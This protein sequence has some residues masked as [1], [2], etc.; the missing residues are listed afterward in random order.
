MTRSPTASRSQPGPSAVTSPAASS[1]GT[2]GWA[3]RV[4]YLPAIMIASA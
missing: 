1:P 2:K 4:W 3:G